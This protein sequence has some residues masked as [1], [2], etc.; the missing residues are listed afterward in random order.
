[1]KFIH[2]PKN[3]DK[4]DATQTMYPSCLEVIEGRCEVKG[5]TMTSYGYVTSG[6]ASICASLFEVKADQGTF[7]SVPGDFLIEAAGQVVLIQRLGFRGL[8]VAGRMEQAGRLSYIGC[9]TTILVPPPRM[10]DPVLNHLHIP[11]GFDQA[12]HTHPSIRLGVVAKGTGLAYSSEPGGAWEEQLKPGTVFLLDAHEMH[13]FSTISS[14]NELDVVAYHPDS[15]YGPT[16]GE[17]PM[18]TRTYLSKR[19]MVR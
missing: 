3:G 17:H 10:G 13:S 7:F 6:R 5:R 15:D 12:Q 18:L 2:N 14:T 9:S 4:L 11:S 16:D 1:V 8:L 19:T